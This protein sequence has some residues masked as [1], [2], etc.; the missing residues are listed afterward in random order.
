MQNAEPIGRDMRVLC[1]YLS[2]TRARRGNDWYDGWV[3]AQSHRTPRP[4]R[5]IFEVAWRCGATPLVARC[6]WEILQAE[7][8]STE[9]VGQ[10]SFGRWGED[11]DP[12]S[13]SRLSFARWST[14][15]MRRRPSRFSSTEPSL[16][17]G[18]TTGGGS[19][20]ME[21]IRSPEPDS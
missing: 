15:D 16:S 19:V 4:L 14:R 3:Q 13:L 10:L 5:M 6:L 20:A 2:A 21:L 17:R 11:L 9:I 7:S 12:D 18:N 8:V 1:G